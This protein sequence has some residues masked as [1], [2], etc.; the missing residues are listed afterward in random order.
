MLDSPTGAVSKEE[1][2]LEVEEALDNIGGAEE[3][4]DENQ[5]AIPEKL[6]SSDDFKIEVQ[7]LPRYFGM[8]Q[9]KKLFNNKLKLNTHKLKPCGPGKNYM[10]IC[11]KNSEDQE[12][13]LVVLD[14][15]DFKGSKLKVKQVLW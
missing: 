9:L 10:Y 1:G 14:G 7:N 11:F 4:M 3:P 5:A 12:K 15:F 2:D 8:G 6:F 13:A